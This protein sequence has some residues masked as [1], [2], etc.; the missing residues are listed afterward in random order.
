MFSFGFFY[1]IFTFV[2]WAGSYFYIWPHGSFLTCS[3]LNIRRLSY[4]IVPRSSV[5]EQLRVFEETSKTMRA[6]LRMSGVMA[7]SWVVVVVV[8]VDSLLPLVLS[9]LVCMS[10]MLNVE[11]SRCSRTG[12]L[13]SFS[14]TGPRAKSQ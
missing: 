7:S 11:P 13:P 8:V 6:T 5:V 2:S 4:R 12:T 1:L 9:H 10:L 14:P 3:I